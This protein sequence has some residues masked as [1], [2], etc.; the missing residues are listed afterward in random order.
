MADVFLS[1][2]RQD[3]ALAA[4]FVELL[5]G[6]GWDVFWDQETRAGTLWPKVL[7][8]ELNNARCLLVLWTS[9]SVASRWVRIEAYEALQNEKLLPVRL[10]NVKPPLE[11]RQ[12]QIFDLIGWTGEPADPRLPRL[13]EDLAAIAKCAPPRRE[14]PAAA[15]SDMRAAEPP[16]PARSK[17]AAREPV[18]PPLQ[19]ETAT[20]V[21]DPEV[22]T[23]VASPPAPPVMARAPAARAAESPIE[24]RSW[25]RVQEAAAA[26][27]AAAEPVAAKLD[28]EPVDRVAHVDWAMPRAR[29]AWI[30]GTAVAAIAAVWLLRTV[31]TTD[32]ALPRP[33]PAPGVAAPAAPKASAEPAPAEVK[34]TAAKIE[35]APARSIAPAAPTITPADNKAAAATSTPARVAS[36]TARA[37]S[38]RC[39]EIAEKFQTTGQ[40]TDEERRF[41]SSKEC[42]K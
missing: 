26:A 28:P 29:T 1:Y 39:I 32:D 27:A 41:L 20:V 12:T 4:R 30:A 15:A 17:P 33:A 13:F 40:L 3:K 10:E 7:E 35:P 9:H 24:T 18:A 19:A 38:A 5:E 11:F 36:G 16:T 21:I 42:A 25:A 37:T 23:A 31:L 2:S 8:D 6:L 34:A 14:R 22:V